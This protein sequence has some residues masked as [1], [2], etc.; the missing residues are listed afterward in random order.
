MDRSCH[1][2]RLLENQVVSVEKTGQDEGRHFEVNSQQGLD[3][4]CSMRD[5][6]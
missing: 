4:G 5:E 1:T 2:N 3:R 6:R